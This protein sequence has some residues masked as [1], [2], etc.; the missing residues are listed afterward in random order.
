MRGQSTTVLYRP[1]GRRE[2]ELIRA[3]GFRTFPPPPPGQSIFKPALTREYAAEVARDWSAMEK[4]RAYS[5][6]YVTRFHVD[7]AFLSRYSLHQV[8]DS[9]EREYLIPAGELDE[10]NDHIRGIIE[11][12]AEYHYPGVPDDAA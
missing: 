6:V 12:V 5:D 7:S 1:V 3:G 2:L 10:F 9:I 4:T 8:A 11:L